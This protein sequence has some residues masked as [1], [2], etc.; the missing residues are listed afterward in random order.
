MTILGQITMDE[1]AIEAAQEITE[2]ELR[3]R[4][5]LL[6]LKP[7]AVAIG[8]CL[9]CGENIA[10]PGRRWCNSDCRDY[11]ERERALIR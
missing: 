1:N 8:E 6:N 7:V 4:L 10:E 9:Y 2:L 11:W 5:L 3:Q